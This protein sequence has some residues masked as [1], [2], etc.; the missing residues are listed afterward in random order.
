MPRLS[1]GR[2]S[3]EQSAAQRLAEADDKTR[4]LM[5][6]PLKGIDHVRIIKKPTLVRHERVFALW[7][8]FVAQHPDKDALPSEI[9]D[10]AVLPAHD[11]TKEFIRYMGYTLQGKLGIYVVKNTIRSSLYTF[12]ALWRQ[13][14]HLTV[15][16]DYR[17]RT[18][19]YLNSADF[20]A[21]SNLTTA[22]R[23]KATANLVDLEILIRGMLDDK[24]Y[25]RTHRSRC[26]VIY[27]SLISALSSERPGAIV[28]SN[29]YRGSNEALYWGDHE[30]WIIPNP[31]DPLRPFVAL[32]LK[33]NLLK[34]YRDDDS[35]FKYFFLIMEPDSHR[36]VDGLMYALILALKDQIFQDVTTIEEIFFP[37]HPCTTAHKL[38]IKESALKQPV[39]RRQVYGN[40]KWTTSLDQALAYS[41]A[42]HILKQISLFLGFIM[43]FTFY[44]FRRCSANNMNAA[45]PEDERRRMMGQ[46]PNS[47]QFFESYQSRLAAIDLGAILADRHE[48]SP[49]NM[50]AMK[51][52]MGMSK[53]R[54]PNAPISLSV[55]E[56]NE[57]N[58]DPEL[59]QFRIERKQIV[60]RIKQE[61]F[62]LMRLLSQED[63]EA[64]EA[65]QHLILDLRGQVRILDTKH[66]VIVS[67][68]TRA[69]VTDKRKRYFADASRRILQGITPI[70][71]VPLAAVQN[72]P[73]AP[74]TSISTA[75]GTE[76]VPVASTSGGRRLASTAS[77]DPMDL[78]RE[79]VYNFTL[80]NA[81]APHFVAC[82]NAFLALPERP[83]PLCF[84]G[85]SP[86]AEGRCPVP[87]CNIECTSALTNH[88]GLNV[89]SHIHRCLMAQ[90]RTEVK[91]EAEKSYTPRACDWVGC[92]S[93]DAVWPS[94]IAFCEHVEGHVRTVSQGRRSF[95]KGQRS[96]LPICR[97]RN[98]DGE[99]CEEDDFDDLQLHLAVSHDINVSVEIAVDYCAICG[100]SFVDFDGDG[101]IWRDHSAEHFET[102]FAPFN[103]RFEGKVDFAQH[104]VLHGKD[105]DN[106]IEFENGEGF[107]GERPEFHGHIE[108]QVPLAPGFCPLCVYNEDLPMEKRMMQFHRNQEFRTHLQRHEREITYDEEPRVCPVPSC[109]TTT[110]DSHKLLEHFVE[111]HRVPICGSTKATKVRRLRLPE[112]PQPE[113]VFVLPLSKSKGK[114][115]AVEDT[116][117]KGVDESESFPTSST[118]ASK[119]RIA[120]RK[121]KRGRCERCWV[122]FPMRP[123]LNLLIFIPNHGNLPRTIPDHV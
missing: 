16:K 8:K 72:I 4:H 46:D 70:E 21:T 110:F 60:A 65:Q 39:C 120:K 53:G 47:N 22:A 99:R 20:K 58:A 5:T 78:V 29:C 33:I 36:H 86:T 105:V 68:E 71:R 1:R 106:Y 104:G 118:A 95:E 64:F 88:G 48:T 6:R 25:I 54:D 27:S 115:R 14:A 35:Y 41:A 116:A 51:T 66:N 2:I 117:L 89:A 59:V 121:Q 108:H 24:R 74:S 103:E 92:A 111:Y 80:E 34:K 43:W 91:E 77:N 13:R 82:V 50:H 107:G 109:G 57:L 28:E 32:V 30:F 3:D 94:R 97:W 112:G 12:F 31:N 62:E 76:N 9:K 17:T 75:P 84:P 7:R 100:E 23:E 119:R 49:E 83:V 67:R 81:G 102:L 55:A 122:Q 63:D 73:K 93:K 44:C 114:G 18:M 61:E 37:T 26:D 98:N 19:D 52:V 45:L 42:A 15:P 123:F 90:Q 87:T 96:N 40:G 85:E 38:A 10:G 56:I 69:I 113:S 79:L 11:T 101:G